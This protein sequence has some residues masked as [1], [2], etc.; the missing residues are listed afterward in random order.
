MFVSM[1]D[2]IK[3]FTPACMKAI[4]IELYGDVR[5]IQEFLGTRIAWRHGK[6]P[7]PRC[8]ECKANHAKLGKAAG[9]SALLFAVAGLILWVV[10]LGVAIMAMIV[11]GA[12]G[13]LI[14][15]HVAL[16]RIPY[17]IRTVYQAKAYP[18]IKELLR[19]G[20]KPGQKP[21]E[22]Q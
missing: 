15:Y 9:F 2:A 1:V 18:P 3:A 10:D 7:V 13:A 6:F 21:P 4:E 11:L 17:K 16:A 20:W 5:H 19:Q 14:G 8:A 22:A 12:M